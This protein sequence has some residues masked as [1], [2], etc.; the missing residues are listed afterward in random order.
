EGYLR[1]IYWESALSWMSGS[2][3][4]PIIS[5]YLNRLWGLEGI[6]VFST[7]CLLVT[8]ILSGKIAKQLGGKL[9]EV[10][11]LTLFL[12]AGITLNLGQLG[13]YDTPAIVFTAVAVY[14]AIKL[15]YET[16]MRRV[17]LLLLSSLFMTLA[18]LSKYI[19]IFALPIIGI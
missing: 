8:G 10:I 5:A 19:A 15:R 1:S 12:F 16:G 14:L 7:L 6:R 11:T 4:Y 13:T 3:L 17:L 18:F 2:Y 9:S